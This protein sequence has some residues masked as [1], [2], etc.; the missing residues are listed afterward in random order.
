MNRRLLAG[1]ALVILAATPQASPESESPVDALRASLSQYRI[2]KWE[3]EQGL[4]LNTVQ[5]VL[6]ARSGHLWIGTA[7]GLA[8][9]DGVRF[10]TFEGSPIP[11]IASQSIFGL[12]EDS[13]GRLWIGYNRGAAVFQNGRFQ[14]MFGPEVTAGRRVWSFAEDRRGV[15]WAG[16]ENGLVRWEDGKV[17]V[18][19]RED[20]LPSLRIRSVAFDTEGTLWIA[21]TAGG[22]ASF[23][24][25]R[26]R[27]LTAGDGLPSIEVRS[28]LAD[29]SGG[30]WA[31]TAGGG[32]VRVE[33]GKIRTYR[34]ADGLPTDQ[35]TALARDREGSLW[36]G[37]WGSGVCRLRE[38]KFRCLSTAEGLAGDQIWS[39]HADRE[40]AVWV[41]TWVGGLN[42]LG[43][44][45]FVVGVPEGLASDNVRS[46]LHARDGATWIS[47]AGGGVH[48][49]QGSRIT[50]IGKEQGLPTDEVAS[51]FEDR[52]GAIWIGTYTSGAARWRNGRIDRFGARE[53]LP[54]LDVRAFEQDDDGTI[55]TGTMAGV[56]TFDGTRFTAV[57]AKN[58]PLE[59]VTALRKTRDGTMWIGTTGHGLIR[60]RAGAFDVL[61]RNEGLLSNWIMSLHED[62][63]GSLWIGTNG[64][65]LNRLRDGKVASI[66]PS[67]GL[68]DPVVQTIIEDLAGYFWITCNRGFYRVARSD[69]D[70]FLDGRV[71]QVTSQSFGPG[72][73]L[74]STSFAGG[75]QPAGA[76]DARGLIWLPSFKGV[77]IVDPAHLP[78]QGQPPAV[79]IDEVTVNG[80]SV[81]STSAVD[82]PP[83]SAPLSIHYSVATL[84]NAER[85]R[86]R[87]RMEGVTNDWV[88][89][90]RSRE[91][92]FP[93]LRYGSY[94][95]QAAA[96]LDGQRWSEPSAPIDVN[97]QP[98]FYETPWFAA[99]AVFATIAGIAGLVW[100]RTHQLEKQHEKMERL[101]AEKTEE[102]R[103]ANEHLS[104]LSFMDALT[105]LANRRRFDET[106]DNEWRRAERTQIP[107][108]VVMA[109]IDAFKAYNDTLGHP[110]GDRCL[111]EVA[112]AIRHSVSR[113]GDLPARYGGEEFVILIPAADHAAAA[114]FAERLRQTCENRAIPHP[115]S[116]VG[117]VVT[118]SLGVA[119]CIPSPELSAAGL[120]AEADAALYRA[121][122]EGRNRVR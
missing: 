3:T 104:R 95:F 43:R 53:G 67:N 102:L 22:L 116:P 84:A 21:M 12:M 50:R 98:R 10:K 82:L 32:L 88:D 83:G 110:Q 96:S 39:I 4:P 13:K 106:L 48:R 7:G 93:G 65:G 118:I 38:Q 105:G 52:E 17:K 56:A 99:L 60:H 120:V 49:L 103:L 9:F 37:T 66:G 35:L 92:S 69:L 29:P 11:E 75:H 63:N 61:T 46:V 101:V 112:E 41:G 68:W 115:S 97:V 15:I 23:A 55:W 76:I 2:E 117:P 18:Y 89:A 1:A 30:V 27:V 24:N 86:F 6:Q 54:S 42:R 91:A 71:P 73:A 70:A 34:V 20:G 119:S 25:D 16:T 87:Y 5:A 36:I 19:G 51:L 45:A 81:P 57:R 78:G 40:D 108:A 14:S 33:G 72:D 85:A 31:A 122:Q 64:E 74:R 90:G 58:A 79:A 62:A 100:L 44:R 107:L 80:R 77:V 111:A 113:A 109:D 59:S 26:L 121:K 28:V 47:T 94:R 114:A 8:R